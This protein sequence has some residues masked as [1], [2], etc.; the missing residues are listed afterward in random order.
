[1]KRF[2]IVGACGL[3]LG[4]TAGCDRL[5]AAG[6]GFNNPGTA[7]RPSDA[8]SSTPTPTSDGGLTEAGEGVALSPD[9]DDFA[10]VAANVVRVEDLDGQG[11]LSAKMFGTAGGD[12][13]MNGLYTYIA[14]FE[15]P[16]E[17]W[18]VFRIGDYLDYEI[19]AVSRGRVDLRLTES[20]LDQA[21][22][23]IGSRETALIVTFAAEENGAPPDR[24]TVTPAR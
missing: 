22:G 7:E 12:P 23:M 19:L 14:F 5:S 15:S 10:Q 24:V 18:R 3:L 6:E 4:G 9:E 17:G 1:M 2:M 16:A 8:P 11:A 21:T 20:T 13:A